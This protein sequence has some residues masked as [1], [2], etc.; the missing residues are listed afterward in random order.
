MND[1]HDHTGA[2][3]QTEHLPSMPFHAGQFP[4]RT[5]AVPERFTG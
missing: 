2:G 1:K 5:L 3:C 4:E